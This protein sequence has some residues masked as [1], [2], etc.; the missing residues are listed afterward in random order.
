MGKL[1][2]SA[3]SKEKLQESINQYFYSENYVITDDNRVYNTQNQ[4]YLDSFIVK[5][6]R[7]RW[8]FERVN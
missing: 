6:T 7:K 3:G 5:L 2:I 8:R 4:K 1:V